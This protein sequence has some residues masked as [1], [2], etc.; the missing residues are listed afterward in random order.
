MR[1]MEQRSAAEKEGGKRNFVR[2]GGQMVRNRN[3]KAF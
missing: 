2:K 3:K 1:M